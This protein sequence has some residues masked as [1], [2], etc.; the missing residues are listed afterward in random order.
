MGNLGQYRAALASAR[1]ARVMRHL[2]SPP[3]N[4]DKA[5]LPLL[6]WTSIH[7]LYID[8]KTRFTLDDHIYLRDIYNDISREIVVKKAAQLGLSEWLVSYALHACDER[9]ADVM[10][11]MPTDSDVSDFS[12]SRFGPALEASEYLSS[13]VVGGDASGGKLRGADKV[14]LKRIRQSFLYLRGGRVQIDA[15]GVA[16]ARQLKSVPIDA[17]IFDEVDE[18]DASAQ[19]I[20]RKRLGH[21]TIAEVRSIS[22]P[23]YPGVG[24]DVLWANSDQREWLT[25]CSAC[26]HWQQI[27][28]HHIVTAFDELERPVSWHGQAEDRAFAACEKCG[29]ELNRLAPGR[30]VP[31]YPGREVVGY[32]PTKFASSITDLLQIVRNLSTTDKTKRR[33]AYN[34]DLGETYVPR[35]GQLTD[36]ILNECHR[37]YGQGPRPGVS[38]YAGADV[39][40]LIHV[41][42]RTGKHPERGETELVFAGAVESFEE[43]GRLMKRFKVRNLVIDALPETRKCRELQGGFDTGVV[44]L[45]YYADDTKWSESANWNE[46]EGIVTL[47]RTRSLDEMYSDFYDVKSLLPGDAKDIEDYYDHLKA[48]VRVLEEKHDRVQVA[49]YVESSADHYAHAE[50]YCKAAMAAPVLR[51]VTVSRS[52][53]L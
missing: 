27:T 41:V 52:V 35:G 37:P 29:R 18:M 21:S 36:E 39:G 7:R 46:N 9:G 6:L 2:K 44:W 48:P 31:R 4:L 16:K 50:N 17:I 23:T 25:P 11:I 49:R 38:L 43:L 24:I 22:T 15:R 8:S 30:W 28:I 34:Q 13:I 40:T 1:F 12:Q 26:G 47:D 14:S 20:G 51:S 10:Y 45:A 33:E 19:E 3:T 53:R 42:I 32:H 5:P